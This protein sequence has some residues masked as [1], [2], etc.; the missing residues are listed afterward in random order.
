MLIEYFNRGNQQ[1][2]SLLTDAEIA[3][4]LA[5]GGVSLE[6]TRDSPLFRQQLS[7][8]EQSQ[9]QFSNYINGIQNSWLDVER[10]I[11]TLYE[12]QCKFSSSLTGSSGGYSRCLFTNS[13]PKLG[14]LSDTLRI[15]SETM[16]AHNAMMVTWKEGVRAEVLPILEDLAKEDFSTEKQIKKEMNESFQEYESLLDNALLNRSKKTELQ[17]SKI[18]KSRSDYELKRFEIVSRINQLDCKKKLMLTKA[19]CSIH[20]LY[21]GFSNTMN[22]TLDK[23]EPIFTSLRESSIEADKVMKTNS[24]LWEGLGK[25][26]QGELIGAMA[27][28][29]APPGALSPVQPRSHSGYTAYTATLTTEVL[30]PGTRSANY[31]DMR[32]ARDDGI[33]KQGYLFVQS[34]VFFGRRRRKWHRL[35]ATKLYTVEVIA[36]SAECNM[37]I[38]CDVFHSTVA[39]KLGDMPHKFIVT[40]TGNQKVELQAEN[41][42][43]MVKWI[44]SIR[45]CANGAGG[46]PASIKLKTEDTLTVLDGPNSELVLEF[47][48]KNPCCAECNA[49]SVSW[50]STSLGLTL[51]EECAV[52][53]RQLTW[54][55]SK[56]KSIKL[57][58][59][60]SWQM[61]LMIQ[62]LGNTVSN[63]IWEKNIPIGWAK[64]QPRSAIEDKSQWI[65]AKYRWYG[66][67]DE[68][69]VRSNEQLA[70]G[71]MEAVL[72]GDIKAI[73]Y[74][75]SHKAD[76]NCSY[77]EGSGRTPLQTAI[78]RKLVNVTA[79]LV[80]NGSDFYAVEGGN[81][82]SITAILTQLQEGYY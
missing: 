37:E 61:N 22:S 57:D 59:F 7:A 68:L 79:F 53:H 78:E 69:R 80:Q 13:F 46:R 43:E 81:D 47:I 40:T 36:N 1:K 18:I 52:V 32:H 58:Q 63:E 25:R 33:F 12:A 35:Y 64:P 73:M 62:D 51:C 15:V 49:E 6:F 45:R 44:T 41:E 24:M 31:E 2:M 14:T 38:V 4:S 77:P 54:A 72:A 27:P 82:E 17:C 74:W 34:G 16:L 9:G 39:T 48:K 50:I 75:L 60:S 66:F 29:G 10:A 11:T 71:I 56:L 42:D 3:S 23:I 19:M 67:V 55:V 30:S 8:Y 28:P 76:I 21:A 20:G 26:L 65:M 70:A 5:I